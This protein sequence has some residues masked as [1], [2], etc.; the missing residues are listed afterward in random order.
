[1]Q[2]EIASLPEVR[3]RQAI[4]LRRLPRRIVRRRSRKIPGTYVLAD[5]AAIC[6]IA[7]LRPLRFRDRSVDFNREVRNALGRIEDARVDDR[8][9]GTGVDAQRAGA[10]L[11]E[12]GRV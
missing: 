5:V 11:I 10:A 3:G 9:G 1:M 4:T 6:V 12:A 2:V 8:A 7:N